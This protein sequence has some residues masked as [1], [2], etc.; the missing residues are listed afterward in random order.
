MLPPSQWADAERAL[1]Q[2]YA[3]DPDSLPRQPVA[4]CWW[5]QPGTVEEPERRPWFLPWETLGTILARPLIRAMRRRRNHA[6]Q[7][8]LWATWPPNH[9]GVYLRANA[10]DRAAVVFQVDPGSFSTRSGSA[11]G[12]LVGELEPNGAMVL[13]TADGRAIWPVY[14][15]M[16]PTSHAPR[17]PAT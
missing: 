10:D 2:A 13:E 1:R 7:S 12:T 11:N 6:E 5:Y 4:Y 8:W 16:A 14:N 9:V 17:R 3:T 15:P